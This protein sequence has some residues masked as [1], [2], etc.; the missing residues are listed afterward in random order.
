MSTAERTPAL[1]LVAVVATGAAIGAL[2][3]WAL[4]EW[5]PGS[6]SWPWPLWWINVTG[7]ALLGLCTGWAALT[8]RPLLA[9]AVGPGL[10]GGFTSVSAAAENMRVLLAEDRVALAGAW[11][12]S[13]V[14]AS[15]AAV[16]LGRQ[17]AARQ[18]AG[19]PPRPTS[20]PSA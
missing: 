4:G 3:R 12:G 2:L 10:L 6:G 18:L 16:L 5:W 13:M 7:A 17:L 9:A 1:A 19:R 20:G 15:V 8:A 14:L 11:W